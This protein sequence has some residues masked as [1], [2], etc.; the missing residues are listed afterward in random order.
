MKVV[1]VGSSEPAEQFFKT[2][3]I[4]QIMKKLLVIIFCAQVVATGAQPFHDIVE[5]KILRERKVLAY[6]PI[7]EA[8]IFWE[9]RVW[10]V[11]DVREKMNQTFTFPGD[12]FFLIL[13]NAALN[14]DIRLFSTENDRFEFQLDSTE[15]R[16]QF[17]TIDTFEIFNPITQEMKLEVI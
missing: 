16:R 5:R 6:K 11:I 7:R 3:K 14:G 9:K 13:Q 10:R 8:D 1:S 2:I 15:V 4:N 17:Y 12:P